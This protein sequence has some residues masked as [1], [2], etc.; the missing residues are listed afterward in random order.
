M[1]LMQKTILVKINPSKNNYLKIRINKKL[2]SKI[3][4][5]SPIIWNLKISNLIPKP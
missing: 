2:F 5:I 1:I 3:K 4:L